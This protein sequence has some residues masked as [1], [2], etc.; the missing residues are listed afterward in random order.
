MSQQAAASGGAR[1]QPLPWAEIAVM[2]VGLFALGLL[3]HEEI[4]AAIGVWES[5]TAYNHCFLVLP[6]ALYLAWERRG[7]LRGLVPE[8]TPLAVLG[9]VPVVFAWLVA[10][11]LG[12]M[13]ARQLAAFALVLLLFLTV[14]GPGI[15]RA[16]AAPLLYLVFLVPFGAFVTPLLQRFTTWSID[17]G[18]GVFGV[19]HAIDNFTI[20]IPEGTFLVAEA[21][22]GLRF[23][24]ASIAFGTLY[25]LLLYRSWLRRA[26]FL[27]ASMVVPVI[28][29]GVRALGIVMIGH[30][31]G[32]AQAAE[33]D[34][35]LYGWLFFVAVQLLL[36]LAGLPFRQDV[37]GAM[38]P[39]GI[40][41]GLR[42]ASP[43]QDGRALA[44]GLLLALVAASGPAVATLLASRSAPDI[45]A[46]TPTLA[47]PAG[48]T[49]ADGAR[50]APGPGIATVQRLI[51]DGEQITL[52]TRTLPSGSAVGALLAARRRAVDDGE[53]A[54]TFTVHPGGS[55]QPWWQAVRTDTPPRVEAV[56]LWIRG[57]PATGGLGDRL[58]L[59]RDSLGG[60]EYRAVL[61]TIEVAPLPA[62]DLP[63]GDQ[64][65][66]LEDFLA[67][68]T[69]LSAEIAAKS[70]RP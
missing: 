48:C 20:D 14:L 64:R 29:N 26:L 65:A 21:C 16:M 52:T 60:G 13:E 42:P 11:R 43:L 17:V 70:R 32:S 55:D 15:C 66:V 27:A 34:H 10:E 36:I 22:A 25:A 49:R 3:F 35:I 23:L 19:P 12:I 50:G 9:A 4:A 40:A 28:A 38:P 5:S 47:I 6:I 54:V 59:A 18:L 51:C 1:V 61:G 2:A 53:E 31:L 46:I 67:S 41:P 57:H 24:I 37:P 56:A 30:V 39:I 44:A 45:V 58:A 7:R 63:A 33:T 69:G 68:E 62:S 8:P